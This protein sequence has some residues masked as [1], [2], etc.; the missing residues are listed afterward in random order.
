MD[1]RDIM[2]SAGAEH[3]QVNEGGA[4]AIYYTALI[5][6]AVLCVITIIGALCTL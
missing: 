6:G 5:I 3:E 2:E 4:E 1:S